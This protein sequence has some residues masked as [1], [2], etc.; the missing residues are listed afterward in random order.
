VD[1]SFPVD[2][3]VT[4]KGDTRVITIVVTLSLLGA[5]ELAPG[6][7]EFFEKRI[8]PVLVEKCYG[9]HAK[10]AGLPKG[11][12]RLDTRAT[13]RRGGTTGPVIVPGRPE[14]SRLLNALRYDGDLKMPPS[15][16]LPERIATDFET[17]I[18]LG[19]IDPR[20]D[21]PVVGSA[22]GTQSRVDFS[23]AGKHW[24]LQPPQQPDVPSVRDASWPRNAVDRFVLARLEQSGLHPV[25]EA[26]RYQLIR[27]LSFDVLGLPPTVTEIRAFVN[28]SS[29][30]AY[31]ELVDRLLASPRYGERWG[32]RWLDVARYAE[33]QA[34][35]FRARRYPNGFRYRDWVI[36][37]FNTD[38]PYDRFV[39][40][41]IAGDLLPAP[42]ADAPERLK[43]LAALGFFALGPVYYRDDKEST[44]QAIADDLEDRVD[45]L[46]RGLLGLS[47]ACARCHDHK[48]DPVTTQDYYAL[49]GVFNSSKYTQPAL[50]PQ[51]VVEARA[52]ATARLKDHERALSEFLTEQ[53]RDQREQLVP[54]IAD[55]LIATLEVEALRKARAAGEDKASKKA[56]GN[57][58]QDVHPAEDAVTVVA[59]KM[60]LAP[61]L[62]RRCEQVV[63]KRNSTVD[64]L[65]GPWN[66]AFGA[67][68]YTAQLGTDERRTVG[69]RIAAETQARVDSLLPHR[70]R[71]FR[72]WGEQIAFVRP[73]N[74]AVVVPGNV[75]LGNLF[76]RGVPG[77]SLTAALVN[78]PNR[79]TADTSSPWIE[80]VVQGFSGPVEIAPGA[81]F[82]FAPLGGDASRHGAI[83]N[84][85]W[86]KQG[87]I[88]T[89]GKKL[90]ANAPRL[91][92]GVGLHANALVTFDLARLRRAA[93]VPAD[94]EL[95]FIADR[96]GINDDALGDPHASVHLAVLVLSGGDTPRVLKLGVNGVPTATEERDGVQ[97]PTGTLPEPLRADGQFAAIR[98]TLPAKASWLTLAATG[99]GT[100][101][102]K[103]TIAN[104]HA[105]FSGAR[106]EFAN[107]PPPPPAIEAESFAD[108]LVLSHVLAESG[109]LLWLDATGTAEILQ[110]DAATHLATLKEKQSALQK[111]V[112]A[113]PIPRAHSLT[114]AEP[115]DLRLNI[116]GDPT[117]LGEI[118]PRGYLT[119]LAG[120][121]QRARGKPQPFESSG[122]GRLELAHAIGSEKNPLT[123]RVIV[124]RLWQGIF[125]HGLVRTASNFGILGERPSH[126]ELLDY[127]AVRLMSRNWS[128]KSIQRDLLLSTTY[129]VSAVAD[130]ANLAVDP[131]NRWLGRSPRRRLEVE[132]WRDAMLAVSGN[133]KTT[134]GGPSFRLDHGPAPRRTLYAHVSRH[135][136]DDLLRLFDFPDPNITSAGRSR[137]T[138]PLQQ[139]FVLNSEFMRNQARAL[140]QRLLKLPVESDAERIHHA[141]LL[142]L[143]R[144]PHPEELAR[145]LEFLASS[146]RAN[147]NDNE[148]AALSVWQQYALVL[149]GTNE[150]LYV[151]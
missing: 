55:G 90:A 50:V 30:T 56:S 20:E 124:N 27:R 95:T 8:R 141:F 39:R 87:G 18:R 26:N 131:D 89:L 11:G 64:V 34:H 68:G 78:D 133:L 150:F 126:P 10:Q 66:T 104:D 15:G 51:S 146:L 9:C 73:E 149:L 122:S 74:R 36:D 101:N 86:D 16:K 63:K 139:L 42:S 130:A 85:G 77:E 137:T 147:D 88:R 32:R 123:A 110:G 54:H 80:R 140:T 40:E 41:Q 105:V 72:R 134:I 52:A 23:N 67:E 37:A 145:G 99:A 118:I 112:A 91:E 60:S 117:Q 45:T 116:R 13:L 12:L 102:A 46:G 28:D 33:D 114:D 82:D 57:T 58:K 35:T 61:A 103:N 14:K 4:R 98:I 44:L 59:K 115:A 119:V 106:L 17:W 113:I 138:V 49:A 81:H 29:P 22:S 19:A 136:L 47:L 94:V 108:A 109:G 93:A 132:P 97:A 43:R 111:E 121:K 62:V 38:M 135:R 25:G 24:S 65:L 144:P 48:Y 21:A 84:D 5:P 53:A 120:P 148:A 142:L 125:G 7:N 143:A 79:A 129:R 2:D 75:P 31:E 69:Q 1:L 3:N 76:D 151:D 83:T 128:L 92:E 127:L 100:G 71:L 96:A 107:E 70:K 6:S